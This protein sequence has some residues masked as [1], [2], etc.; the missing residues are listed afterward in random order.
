MPYKHKRDCPVCNKPGL[1]YMSNHLRQVHHL[2]GDERKKWLG[3]A[4]FSISHKHCFGSL[5]GRRSHTLKEMRCVRKKTRSV[6]KPTKPAGKVT[7]SMV[8]KPYPEQHGSPKREEKMTNAPV[9]TA[10]SEPNQHTTETKKVEL[11]KL[12]SNTVYVFN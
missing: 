2:Y 11:N 12:Y 7:A 8:T 5:T 4:R 1:L 9:R 6:L 3:R 10:A